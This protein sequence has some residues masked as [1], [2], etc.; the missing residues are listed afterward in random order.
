MW[1]C[2]KCAREFKKENQGHFCGKAQTID[3]YIES[4]DEDIQKVMIKYREIIKKSVPELKEKISWGMA[5]FYDR[6]NVIHF[7]GHKKHIGIYPGPLAVEAFS[8]ELKERGLKFSKGAIQI[9][10]VEEIPED[11]I[12]RLTKFCLINQ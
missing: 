12:D 7:A 10:Y 8:P 11:F 6:K 5:T 4:F 3:E 9:P 2:E 1:K